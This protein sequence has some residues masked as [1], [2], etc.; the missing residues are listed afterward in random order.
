MLP[1]LV[2]FHFLTELS[3]TLI[4]HMQMYLFLLERAHLCGHFCVGYL[5]L[6][7]TNPWVQL[8]AVCEVRLFAIASCGCYTGVDPTVMSL[9]PGKQP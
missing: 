1:Y 9:A 3:C 7:L 5:I 6:Q 8:H 2:A 4:L